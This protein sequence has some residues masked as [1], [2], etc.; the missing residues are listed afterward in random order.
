MPA[1]YTIDIA[2]G[3][4][5]TRAFGVITDVE[6]R[7]HARTLK[8]DPKFQPTFRQFGDFSEVTEV[9]ITG[10]GIASIV[11]SANP[12]PPDAVRA[13]FAPNATVFGLARMFEIRQ[14]GEHILVTRSR[15]EAERHV[16]LSPGESLR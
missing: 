11:G 1:D 3:I 2:R 7:E 4:V 15:E 6:L 10:A 9:Q 16:G 14:H 12:F 5:F 8:S 13:L